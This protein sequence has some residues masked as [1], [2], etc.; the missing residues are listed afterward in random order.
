MFDIKD[1]LLVFVSQTHHPVLEHHTGYIFAEYKVTYRKPRELFFTHFWEV[2]VYALHTGAK[3]EMNPERKPD[4]VT[5]LDYVMNQSDD[6]QYGD[7]GTFAMESAA[8][9]Q[10][11]K[12][13]KGPSKD[14]EVPATD[15]QAWDDEEERG[16]GL[17]VEFGDTL[18]GGN[19]DDIDFFGGE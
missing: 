15:V 7:G 3:I 8:R 9:W 5:A 19:I 17:G 4:I 18:T 11:N 16:V 12:K 1:D 2:N 6:S 10:K 14:A 13:G